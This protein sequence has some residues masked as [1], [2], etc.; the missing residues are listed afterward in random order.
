MG[1]SHKPEIVSREGLDWGPE[2]KE[3]LERDSPQGPLEGPT[4]HTSPERTMSDFGFP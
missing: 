4:C 3:M 2:S 1:K